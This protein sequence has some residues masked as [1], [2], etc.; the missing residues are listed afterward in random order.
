MILDIIK[1]LNCK[2]MSSSLFSSGVWNEYITKQKV[3]LM[4]RNQP[5]FGLAENIRLSQ[6][7]ESRIMTKIFTYRGTHDSTT[8]TS[9]KGKI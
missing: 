3:S 6:Y 1:F 2:Y 4:G 5:N 9:C 7:S 8:I